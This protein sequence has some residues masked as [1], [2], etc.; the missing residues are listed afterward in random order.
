MNAPQILAPFFDF[1]GTFFAA[2]WDIVKNDV[3]DS[4]ESVFYKSFFFGELGL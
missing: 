1:Y 3:R 2:E 4:F